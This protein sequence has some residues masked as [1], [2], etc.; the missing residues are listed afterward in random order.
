[1]SFCDMVAVYAGGRND[2][3]I[4]YL[5]LVAFAGGSRINNDSSRL[6]SLSIGELQHLIDPAQAELSVKKAASFS[7]AGASVNTT[8]T[9]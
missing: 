6:S 9:A 1:M 2:D 4:P 8:Y 5:A 7:S 3:C